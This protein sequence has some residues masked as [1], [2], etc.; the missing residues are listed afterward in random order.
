MRHNSNP[1]AR[2]WM[3]LGGLMVV[4]AAILF[5]REIPSLRRELR[6]MRM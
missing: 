5:V 6:I 1:L 3:A 4:G 2:L